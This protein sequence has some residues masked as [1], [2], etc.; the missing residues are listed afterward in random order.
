MSV[1]ALEA[2]IFD[3]DGTLYNQKM[4]RLRMFLSLLKTLCFHVNTWPIIKVLRSFRRY[5]ESTAFIDAEASLESQYNWVA[6]ATQ[7]NIAL[8]RAVVEE[9]M[10]AKP[11]KHLTA[12][13]YPGVHIFFQKLKERRIMIGIFS[14]YP[15]K[16]KLTAM[17]L[18]AD[19][20]VCSTD[21]DVRRLKPD[22][23]GLLKCCKEMRV[24]PMKT[25]YIGDR[26]DLDGACA[27]AADIHYCIIPKSYCK[28]KRFYRHLSEV[29]TSV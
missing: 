15:A 24:D 1:D 4:L 29:I 19:F 26:D 13:Q 12:C 10:F 25:L 11:L 16:Q 7:L 5:R 6:E 21:Q 8:V 17:A 18:E 9:W 23:K 20:Y 22:P 28:V 27:R 14:D 3:V 2:V